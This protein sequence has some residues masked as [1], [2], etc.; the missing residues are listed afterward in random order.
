MLRFQLWMDALQSKLT[1]QRK[2]CIPGCQVA[3][4]K[5]VRRLLLASEVAVVLHDEML[6]Q[7]GCVRVY[8]LLGPLLAV[9]EKSSLLHKALSS[10]YIALTVGGVMRTK[11]LVGLLGNE[12]MVVQ[13]L[14]HRNLVHR[15]LLPAG[16]VQPHP[17]QPGK[18]QPALLQQDNTLPWPSAR[19]IT[20]ALTV[21]TPECL[22]D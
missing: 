11:C 16:R 6:I 14:R 4:L 8:H 1:T 5:S 7:E 9:K 3:R 21:K 12:V 10:V 17:G 22:H 19:Q 2:C 20:A 15:I 13:N 18:R